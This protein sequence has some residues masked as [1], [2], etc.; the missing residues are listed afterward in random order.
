MLN[1]NANCHNIGKNFEYR[2]VI[3]TFSEHIFVFRTLSIDF[4]QLKCQQ[5]QTNKTKNV[6]LFF[7]NLFWIIK[8]FFLIFLREATLESKVAPTPTARSSCY[9]VIRPFSTFSCFPNFSQTFLEWGVLLTILQYTRI[10]C[11]NTSN[12]VHK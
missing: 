1:Q 10:M 8:F 5:R 3:S 12:I 11:L 7:C 2:T 6:K 4:W 9:R